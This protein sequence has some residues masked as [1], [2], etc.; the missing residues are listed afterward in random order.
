[1]ARPDIMLPTAY[2]IICYR[3]QAN[4]QGVY[5]VVECFDPSKGTWRPCAKLANGRSGLG[6]CAV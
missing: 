3:G 4:D 1:M 6:L 2:F 5:D